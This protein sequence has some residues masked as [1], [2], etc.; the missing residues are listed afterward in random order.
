MSKSVYITGIAGMIGFHTAISLVKRGYDVIGC[1]NFNDYYDVELKKARA[2]ILKQYDVHVIP[3]DINDL[4]EENFLAEFPD[5]PYDA[6]IHLAA[7]ANPRH[8]M[9]YPYLYIDTNIRGTQN[10]IDAC[11]KAGVKNVIYASSSCV[12]HGQPLPWNEHDKPDHQA[13]PY[14]WSKRTNECQ[15]M[16][17]NIMKTVG[18]RFFTVYG[19]YG[20]PD[21]ALFL[22]TKGII[23]GTPITA[24][25]NGNMVRDFT[26]VDD[27]VESV[28]R[29]TDGMVT[30]E[31]KS[32]HEIYNIGRGEQVQLM[33]FI[34]CI[35]EKVGKK[36]I[37]DFKPAHPADV[38]ATWADTSKLVAKTGYSPKVSIPA[39]VD[40]FV[41]W[42]RSYYHV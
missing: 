34:K 35:E 13:C 37:I 14:G 7:Y 23:D 8:S 21:M 11:Q 4:A 38:P 39:G 26:Y 15:F 30:E 24:F 32:Y 33:D 25:N 36:A 2:R 18:L 9:E 3:H 12:M 20:R 41:D 1:D 27:I 40:K 17:S 29:L 31:D 6:V 28:A 16:Y 5:I 22:F 19:P 10:I 42:Y